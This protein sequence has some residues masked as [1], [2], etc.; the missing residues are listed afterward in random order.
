MLYRYRFKA[1]PLNPN[2]VKLGGLLGVPRKRTNANLTQPVSPQL[3]TKK[4]AMAR[5]AQ[6][7]EAAEEMPDYDADRKFVAQPLPD[8][9]EISV[10]L[11]CVFWAHLVCIN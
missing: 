3:A 1:K 9:S 6:G 5:K 4:L 2:I 10:S 11:G 8:F 7:G